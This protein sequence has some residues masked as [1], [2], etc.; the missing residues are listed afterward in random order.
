MLE[1][2]SNRIISISNNIKKKNFQFIPRKKS[3]ISIID[4]GSNS[5]RLV[6]YDKMSR[7]PRIIY[8]EKVFCSLAK[9]LEVDNKIPK[10]NYKKTLNTIK[11]FYKI[12]ID[13]K[14]SELFIFATAA[15]R[16]AENGNKLKK[17]IE[18]ITNGNMLILSED[19]EVKLSTQGLLSS[20]PGAGGIM[21]D[22]GGG[23]LELAL[24]K[25]GRLKKFTSLRIGVVRFLRYYQKN[26]NDCLKKIREAI[27]SIDWLKNNNQNNLYAIG[28]SF[29][30]LAKV[31]IW[32]KNYPLSI[33]Q[34]YTI[35]DREI[36]NLIEVSSKIKSKNIKKIDDIENERIK[37]IP[38][39]S[40][41]LKELANK[42]L[43]KKMV[44]CSQGL[45]EGFLFSL[46]DDETKE[47]DPLTFTT[48]R[49]SMN[50]NNSFFDG[51]LIFNWLN[52][53]FK[54][55]N[56]NFKRLRLAASYLAELSYWHNFK[57]IESDYALNTVL[58]YP[59]LSLTHEQR[60]FLGLSI[61]TAC[62]G[63]AN[64][65]NFIKYSKL[66]KKDAINAAGILGNGIKLAYLVSGG[67]YRNLSDYSLRVSNNE[68]FLITSNKKII[69]TSTKIKRT[70]K[71]LS[72][73]IKIKK[74]KLISPEAEIL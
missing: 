56:D 25:K 1:N 24:I 7:V 30:C 55:E 22:L 43:P 60:I 41:I 6:A 9:N 26:K 47:E 46:L 27:N 68:I 38:V 52:P 62:G 42:I 13:I 74:I 58:Y 73:L 11:R 8:S 14:S 35:N 40:L 63:K 64:N 10:K 59:F 37:T 29:R 70:L 19:D 54:N 61:Y 16:E 20:F 51:K 2:T 69:K 28:G 53:I 45:R 49:M 4:I 65:P 23:S 39:A 72:K 3:K 5:I 66:L 57:D 31:D 44:F 32:T 71:K 18:R 36:K 21:A 48:K 34:G 17:E 12:S 15:V 33:I 50:F 67:L